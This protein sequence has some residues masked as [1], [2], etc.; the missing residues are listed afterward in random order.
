[1]KKKLKFWYPIILSIL[2]I[3]VS[4][5]EYKAISTRIVWGFIVA[6]V[7]VASYQYYS[8]SIKDE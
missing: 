8:L 4:L 3:I 7:V 1:M 5:L 2:F 6:F